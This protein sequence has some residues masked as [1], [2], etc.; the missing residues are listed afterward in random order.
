MRD[1]NRNKRRPAGAGWLRLGSI[2]GLSVL[3]LACGRSELGFNGARASTDDTGGS[4]LRDE[5]DT[6]GDGGSSPL[7]SS[8][9][10]LPSGGIHASGG[11]LIPAGGSETSTGGWS[12]G[13]GGASGGSGG[14]STGGSS[15]GSAGSTG[16][17]SGG[18][19]DVPPCDPA[20]AEFESP[21]GSGECIIDPCRL[22][23][24]PEEAICIPQEDRT[25]FCQ[26][27]D[28]WEGP[29]CGYRW[30][31]LQ[32]PPFSEALQFDS[33]GNAWF[34]TT[35]GLLYWNLAGTPESTADDDF[36]LFSELSASPDLAIDSLDRLWLISGK[37]L[38]RFDPGGTP[39]DLSDDELIESEPP[40][41]F[42]EA[43]LD[44]TIDAQDRAW[45]IARAATGV[46]VLEN[47]SAFNSDAANWSHLF[48]GLRVL[49]LAVEENGVWL[50]TEEGLRYVDLGTS[51]SS[52]ADDTWTDFDDIALINA[53]EISGI[54]IG[55][56]GTK[57][58]NT[59]RGIVT[60]AD[61]GDAFE[62]S[63]HTWT[64]WSPPA[65]SLAL[66]DGPL[67]ELGPD[68]VPW[69]FLPTGAAVRAPSTG[70][71]TQYA[72]ADCP[73]YPP[74]DSLNVASIQR[75]GANRLWV[76]AN[77]NGYLF[78]GGNT[79]HDPSDDSWFV[80]RRSA[81]RPFGASVS[82]PSGGRWVMTRSRSI[83]P[84]S[85]SRLMYYSR[86]GE[87]S[88]AWDDEW[89]LALPFDGDAGCFTLAG[90]DAQQHVWINFAYMG[91]WG[92]SGLDG[93]AFLAGAREEALV[94]YANGE[95]MVEGPISFALGSDNAVFSGRTFSSGASLTDKSDDVWGA[96]Q[97]E[98]LGPPRLDSLG[99]SWFT[100]GSEAAPAPLQRYHDRGTPEDHSDDEFLLFFGSEEIP[101][102]LATW[103]WIDDHDWK[104]LNASVHG[105]FTHVSFDDGGTPYDLSDDIWRSYE[106][107]ESAHGAMLSLESIDGSEELWVTTERDFGILELKR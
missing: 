82:E 63:G 40:I 47:P 50:S 90:V 41:G 96:L 88:N 75:D 54:V 106:Q 46:R 20:E 84:N 38:L 87:P 51:L 94:H 66:G 31:P 16:G 52:E 101:L 76:N 99:Y 17:G 2:F 6:L 69:L 13:S 19:D 81:H 102:T 23:T 100:S 10:A 62:T 42:F 59:E 43:L 45:I 80:T 86:L 39:R 11:A 8:G 70:A 3:L 71:A 72:P 57:W 56:D 73:L 14:S 104:W 49:A 32:V 60:L 27:E 93:P 79:P 21:P 24:C 37:K 44:V 48:I 33:A 55:P 18:S 29:E 83:T 74:G 22:I 92:T 64:P 68:G 95:D 15:G 35:K 36:A 97:Y 67:F 78:V 107:F 12:A 26:C 28:G 25:A 103:L 58:L 1:S 5:D 34:K 105:D 85:C 53:Q 7:F 89:F 30:N 77:S 98:A 91:Y 9:G 4:D 61:G 65:T